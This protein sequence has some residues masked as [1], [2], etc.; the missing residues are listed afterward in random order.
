MKSLP[1]V[2]KHEP[3]LV[4]A[5]IGDGPERQDLEKLVNELGLKEH[6]LFTGAQDIRMVSYYFSLADVF[7]MITRPSAT[8]DQESFGMVYLEAGVFGKPVIAS[9]VGGVL[10]TVINNETGILLDDI[11]EKSVQEAI[12]RLFSS[13]ELMNKFG[14]QGRKR[15]EERFCWSMQAKKLEKLL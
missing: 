13:P 9:N 14:V 1:E 3:S 12:I 8:G 5:I 6:V 11:S 7:I 10:E 2:I 4:Y 15:V